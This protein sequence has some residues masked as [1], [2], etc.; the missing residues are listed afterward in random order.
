[1]PVLG[2]GFSCMNAIDLVLY[3]EYDEVVTADHM[4]NN[5]LEHLAADADY[6]K[7]FNTGNLIQDAEG[8][9]KFGKL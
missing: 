8:Y 1:M 6:Y 7:Q 3:C 5:L 2:D 4:A 9:F